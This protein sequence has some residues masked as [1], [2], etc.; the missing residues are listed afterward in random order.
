MMSVE[1]VSQYQLELDSASS[2]SR[3]LLRNVN[4]NSTMQIPD[5]E[6][7]IEVMTTLHNIQ[8]ATPD[9]SPR[10]WYEFR[11]SSVLPNSDTWTEH[12]TGFIAHDEL[13]IPIGKLLSVLDGLELSYLANPHVTTENPSPHQ[14]RGANEWYEKF[15][16]K[17]LGYG[18]AFQGLS[19]IRYDDTEEQVVASLAL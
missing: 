4:I 15:S 13:D 14:A 16:E 6:F 1:A 8:F 7:G 12:C 9:A 3:Y 10:P 18:K 11:I 17:G 5:D 2:R 19:D